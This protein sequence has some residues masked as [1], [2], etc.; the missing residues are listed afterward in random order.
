MGHRV[1]RRGKA[2]HRAVAQA[3][4]RV[5]IP[6]HQC[7]GIAEAGAGTGGQ[8]GLYLFP[9][10]MILHHAGIGAAVI[11]HRAVGGDPCDAPVGG[12]E[13]VKIGN[14]FRF[15]RVGDQR[16]LQSQLL[17]L[18]VGKVGVQRPQDQHHR[19][20]Q[21]RQGRQKNRA[22]NPLRHGLRLHPVANATDGA[23]VFAALP[24]L[25]AQ[26]ADVYVHRPGL[27]HV[28]RAPDPLQQLI[29]GKDPAGMLQ[30]ELQ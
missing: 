26:G 22:K 30:K 27:P 14:P 18:N 28:V 6:L 24:Q 9:L 19:C 3:L 29:P 1:L 25:R 23:D 16:R 12:I 8:R 21:H 4:R 17:R 10:Q 15:Q 11:K 7:V 20:Q 13:I 5:N 2:K